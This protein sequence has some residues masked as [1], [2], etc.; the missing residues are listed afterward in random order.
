MS[1]Y[2]TN[3][4]RYQGESVRLQDAMTKQLEYQQKL[5]PNSAEYAK[6]QEYYKQLEAQKQNVDKQA[7]ELKGPAGKVLAVSQTIAGSIS[8]LFSRFGYRFFMTIINHIKNFI[9]Q[10]DSAMTEIQM[11]T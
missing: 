6:S 2:D 3:L 10:F 5:D 4:E 11:V 7:D 8:N 1:T 9:K